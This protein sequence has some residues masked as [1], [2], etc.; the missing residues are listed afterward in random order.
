MLIILYSLPDFGSVP[1]DSSVFVF[2]PVTG[3]ARAFWRPYAAS[4]RGLE[5]LAESLAQEFEAGPLRIHALAPDPMRT[6]LRARAWFAEDPASVAPPE[7]A[8][9]ACAW[10]FAPTAAPLRNRALGLGRD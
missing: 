3:P 9:G 10:L 4:M 6:P 7:V 1:N 5:W 2:D 8:G